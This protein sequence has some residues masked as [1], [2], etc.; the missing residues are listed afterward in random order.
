MVFEDPLYTVRDQVFY[1]PADPTYDIAPVTSSH[2]QSSTLATYAD[3]SIY[4]IDDDAM[5]TYERFLGPAVPPPASGLE[6]TSSST[7]DLDY[8]SDDYLET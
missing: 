1:P 5:S 7:S 2:P 8:F 3:L 4:G 6:R